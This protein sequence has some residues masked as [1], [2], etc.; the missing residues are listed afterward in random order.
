MTKEQLNDLTYEVNAAIIEV[1]KIVGPGLLES[2]YHKCLIHELELRGIDYQTEFEIRFAYKDL[3]MNADFRCD[4]LI[5]GVLVLELKAV[6][7]IVPYFK[8]KLMNYMKLL[9]VPKGIL[10]NFNVTNIMKE[11]HQVFVNKYYNEL[12]D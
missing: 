1:H 12:P 8:A 5:E 6:Q 9:E 3:N 11:G 2:V 7:E 10:V 4:L